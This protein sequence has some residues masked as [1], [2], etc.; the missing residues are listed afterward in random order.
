MIHLGVQGRSFADLWRVNPVVS[1]A[2]SVSL[3]MFSRKTQLA[4]E[5][6]IW[7]NAEHGD[8]ELWKC[9]ASVVEHGMMVLFGYAT[10]FCPF[11]HNIGVAGRLL[12]LVQCVLEEKE[13]LAHCHM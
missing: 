4:A 10:V 3:S 11:V 2:G 13:V 7:V 1:G 8:V 9:C 12:E 6:W 5:V